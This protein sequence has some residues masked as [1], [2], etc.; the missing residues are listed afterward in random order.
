MYF[1]FDFSLAGVPL[2]CSFRY[3][4]TKEYFRSYQ[5]QEK[6][7]NE[8]PIRIP[9]PDWRQ[10][11]SRNMSDSP[12]T[13]H[14]VFAA[15]ASDALLDYD[16]VIVHAVA[17]RWR[18]GAYLICAES[19]TGKSTQARFLREL[20][21]GEFG[22]ICGD[23]PVLEFRPPEPDEADNAALPP[24]ERIF[25]H[26]S[27]WNG[28]ENWQG[29]EAAPLRGVILLERGAE[30]RLVSLTPKEAAVTLYPAFLQL[31]VFA[32][33]MQRIA[34]LETDIL[35]STPC[36]KLTSCEVPDSTRLLLEQIFPELTKTQKE[37]GCDGAL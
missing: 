23:R 26:P 29:A 22:I 10:I 35:Q 36:W 13:E 20:R 21:P 37:C 4:R 1:D 19:G 25:V 9:D 31:A 8:T 17:L 28:K 6:A 24:L 15:Y 34:A 12:Y 27:P 16:R 3:E 5:S 33:K 30:N 2:S 18:D 14:S 11:L 32:E 7:R